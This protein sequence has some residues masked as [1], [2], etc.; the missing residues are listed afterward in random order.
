[1]SGTKDHKVFCAFMQAR[2]AF[3]FTGTKEAQVDLVQYYAKLADWDFE[4][5]LIAAAKK[6]HSDDLISN[7]LNFMSYR[8]S[9]APP[10]SQV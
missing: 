2:K 3:R 4:Q 1:M 10:G 7:K 6:L 9:I 8:N 5:S